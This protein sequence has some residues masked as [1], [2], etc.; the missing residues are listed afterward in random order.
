M[1]KITIGRKAF[2][3]GV[4]VAAVFVLALTFAL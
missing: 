4:I 1:D 2:L 3:F